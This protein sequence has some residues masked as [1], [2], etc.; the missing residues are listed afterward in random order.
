M[1]LVVEP[2]IH[3]TGHSTINTGIL[4]VLRAAFPRQTLRFAA[5]REHR[6]E[7]Q[8]LNAVEPLAD[9]HYQTIAI[10]PMGSPPLARAWQIWRLLRRLLAAA[11]D[12]GPIYLLLTCINGP[13]VHIAQWFARH[14]RYRGRLWCHCLL[15]GPDA[16]AFTWRSRNPLV[17]RLDLSESIRRAPDPALRLLVLDAATLPPLEA[18]APG[19]AARTGVFQLSLLPQEGEGVEAVEGPPWRIALPGQA[20]AAKGIHSFVRIA[21]RL[22]ARYPGQFEFHLVGRL[23]ADV[24][25]KALGAVIPHADHAQSRRAKASQ[26]PRE[27]YLALLKSMHYVCLPYQGSYYHTGASGV[28]YDAVN[29]RLPMLVMP[30]PHVVDSFARFGDIG[31]LCED[32]AALEAAVAGLA[33]HPDRARYLAQRAQ[34]GAMRETFMPAATG[35]ALRSWIGQDAPG[36]LAALDGA[37][38]GGD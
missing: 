35:Q 12:G 15:H 21:T 37:G 32:E 33:T 8:R 34:L 29:L 30:A 17:R 19:L 22:S 10:P 5:E 4:R 26:L 24:A 23:A 14:P 27:V 25:D 18:L 9:C 6:G 2:T 36:L 13:E 11:D 7:V 38:E 28:F 3:G 1:M 31:H 16:G 20:T